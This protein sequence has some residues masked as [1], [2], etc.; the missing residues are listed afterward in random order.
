MICGL[1]GISARNDW[2]GRTLL[3][4]GEGEVHSGTQAGPELLGYSEEA[5]QRRSVSALVKRQD[6]NL[7]LI[8]V[9]KL[10]VMPD[11]A[12]RREKLPHLSGQLIARDGH[13]LHCED[14]G[15]GGGRF[16]TAPSAI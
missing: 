9:K 13:S 12:I 4:L 3:T 16:E 2:S 5:G 1:R 14:L 11:C 7:E 15:F 8:E 10:L 6:K